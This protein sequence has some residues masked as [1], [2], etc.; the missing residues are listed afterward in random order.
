MEHLEL[1]NTVLGETWLLKTAVLLAIKEYRNNIKEAKKAI[2]KDPN[3]KRVYEHAIEETER[4]F[5]NPL[6]KLYKKKIQ[7]LKTT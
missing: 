6:L 7:H 1:E 3:N 5:L 2:L 4:L